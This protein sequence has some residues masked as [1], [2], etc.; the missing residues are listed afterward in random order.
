MTCRICSNSRG[1]VGYRVR[2]MNLG[3]RK[4]LQIRAFPPEMEKYYPSRY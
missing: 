2:E 4:C 1:N 3:L